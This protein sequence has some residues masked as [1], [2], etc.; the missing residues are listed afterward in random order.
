MEETRSVLSKLKFKKISLSKIELHCQDIKI[1]AQHRFKLYKF[2]VCL[3]ES[4]TKLGVGCKDEVENW[5]TGE[6][7][8]LSGYE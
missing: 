6:K 1:A 5:F 4:L 3:Q 7:L 2:D 8:G